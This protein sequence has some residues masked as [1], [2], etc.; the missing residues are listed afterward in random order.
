M[1]EGFVC[2]VLSSGPGAWGRG[3]VFCG[4]GRQFGA[5]DGASTWGSTSPCWGGGGGSAPQEAGY[6]EPEAGDFPARTWKEGGGLDRGRLEGPCPAAPRPESSAAGTSGTARWP[7][8]QAFGVWGRGQGA[9]EYAE[10]PQTPLASCSDAKDS[11][12][13]T[14]PGSISARRPPPGRKVAGPRRDTGPCVPSPTLRTGVGGWARWAPGEGRG[15]MRA[16]GGSFGTRGERDSR[17]AS[18]RRTPEPGDPAIDSNREA[19]VYSNTAPPGPSP[20]DAA[21]PGAPSAWLGRSP[22]LLP[23]G[24]R[25]PR[26]DCGHSRRLTSSVGYGG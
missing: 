14:A 1:S 12:G 20:G 7:G 9:L 11:R 15:G 18:S 6:W 26:P 24:P 13:H 17:P 5:P 8:K 4:Q 22:S 21:R 23:R 16:A 10:P 3:V 19:A 25:P 2:L